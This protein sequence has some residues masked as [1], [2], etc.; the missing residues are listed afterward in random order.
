MNRIRVAWLAIFLLL[1]AV[2]WGS[3]NAVE[4]TFE[5]WA[6]R[7]SLLYYSGIVAIGMMSVGMILAMRLPS[8]ESLL[9]GLDKHYRLHKWLGISA[10]IAA[11]VHWLVKLEP[12]WL[13]K[14]GFVAPDTFK[15][16]VGT[17]GFF[18]HADPFHAIR[19]FAKDLGE[20]TIYALIVLAVIA[21]WRRLPYRS[22]FKTHRLM[23]IVY[24]L[25]AFHSVVLFS[26]LGWNSPIGWLM[27]ALMAAG[28]VG[29][30]V[31]LLGRTGHGQQ[32]EGK[33]ERV[34]RHEQDNMIEIHLKVDQ[35]WPGH[36]AGQFA[37]LTFD[38]KEGAHPFS[39][40]SAWHE[41]T[42]DVSFHIK[43]LGDFTKALPQQLSVGEVVQIE[44]PYGRF[45]F[46]PKQSDQIW[47]AGGVGM[48]PFLA[49]L[50]A[51]A[52]EPVSKSIHFYLCLR[53]AETDVV[54]TIRALCEQA[55]VKLSTVVSGTHAPLTGAQVRAD[56]PDWKD[57]H[58]WFCGPAGLGRA[59][60]QDL[61]GHGLPTGRFHQELFEMR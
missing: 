19:G 41:D 15:T 10:V 54:Q 44:G 46:E 49:R 61:V 40:S 36:H 32:H 53:N 42:R 8:I 25:L 57:A 9:G 5:P 31:S 4:L 47:I 7:K 23:A 26:K 18:D 38:P 39:I 3:L 34:V 50:Q 20:W 12:K 51:I 21:I 33:L 24:L 28:V 22:F 2:Y 48:T 30:V 59:V 16:P 45:E 55:G 29:A 37:F 52:D 6:L 1:T 14:H 43:R 35:G 17:V 11:V 13:V 27:G 58:V 60:R 56:N